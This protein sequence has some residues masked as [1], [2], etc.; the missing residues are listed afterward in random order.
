MTL[1]LSS[2]VESALFEAL[3]TQADSNSEKEAVKQVHPD[4]VA[5]EADKKERLNRFAG[6]EADTRQ[7]RGPLRID[8]NSFIREKIHADVVERFPAGVFRGNNDLGQPAAP[9]SVLS[10]TMDNASG[11]A[12]SRPLTLAGRMQSKS[13]AVRMKRGFFLKFSYFTFSY[14]FFPLYS[15]LRNF[16]N[17]L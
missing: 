17:T 10:D 11:S 6:F 9:Y 3:Q 8:A 15:R 12:S 13:E 16:T 7:G 5:V 4:F 14:V 2:S 1:P